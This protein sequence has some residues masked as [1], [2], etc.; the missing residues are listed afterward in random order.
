[1]ATYVRLDGR[2]A[3]H[4]ITALF[5]LAPLSYSA[6]TIVGFGSAG[7]SATAIAPGQIVR[8]TVDGIQATPARIMYASGYPWPA[9]LGDISVRLISI[10]PPSSTTNF[11]LPILSLEPVPRCPIGFPGA[12]SCPPL[13]TITVQIPYS[14][15]TS[16][17]GQIIVSENG[18]AGDPVPVSF[19]ADQVQMIAVIRS[20]GSLITPGNPADPGENVALFAYGL[21]GVSPAAVAGQSPPNPPALV[22]GSFRLSYDIRYDAPPYADPS[23][24]LP[25]IQPDFVGLVPG[26]AGLYQINFMAPSVPA[27]N[28]GCPIAGGI[29]FTIIYHSNVTIDLRSDHSF[30]GVG[31]CVKPPR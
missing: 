20:N 28:A 4:L 30:H 12:L 11:D 22:T 13:V 14:V 3:K 17:T 9:T 8:V 7:T 10:T 6:T 24:S 1:M 5:I 2:M 25:Q 23:N 16:G 18:V 31:I 15:P 27:D 21:G 29:I 26:L 19:A